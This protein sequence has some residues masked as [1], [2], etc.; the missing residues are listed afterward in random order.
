[1]MLLLMMLK[2]LKLAAWQQVHNSI[3]IFWRQAGDF[4]AE[5]WAKVWHKNLIQWTFVSLSKFWEKKSW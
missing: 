3:F 1:M 4:V 5:I 2:I